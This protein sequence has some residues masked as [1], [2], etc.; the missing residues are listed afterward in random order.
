MSEATKAPLTLEEK[1]DLVLVNQSVLQSQ[2]D[3]VKAALVRVIQ[4]IEPITHQAQDLKPILEALRVQFIRVDPKSGQITF[5]LP[6][7]FS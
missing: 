2:M 3:T 6:G 7:L 4:G 5:K 1:I